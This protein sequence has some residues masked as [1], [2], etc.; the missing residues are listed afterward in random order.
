[1]VNE[2]SVVER[3]AIMGDLSVLSPSER[4]EYYRGM[5]EATGLNPVTRPFGYIDVDG[6][7]EL[8]AKRAATDQL[9]KI[10]GVDII[11]VDVQYI[12]DWIV[13]TAKARDKLGRQDI[14]IGAVS[15]RDMRGNFGNCLMKAITKAKRRVTL[16]LCGLGILDESEIDSVP[17]AHV[18]DEGQV[19]STLSLEAPSAEGRGGAD[20]GERKGL[21]PASDNLLWIRDYTARQKFIS[22]ACGTKGLSEAEICRALGVE[23]LDQFVG[24]KRMAMEAVSKLAAEKIASEPEAVEDEQADDDGSGDYGN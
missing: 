17:S 23:K 11:S 14:D 19:E 22:W 9:R 6:K 3:A 7:L 20:T 24:S 12:D 15:K 18:L 10:N 4:W 2:L 16:S 8:Y 5:C 1:M 21:E 13:A